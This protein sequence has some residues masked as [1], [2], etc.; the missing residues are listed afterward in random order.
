MQK[1]KVEEIQVQID[2][3]WGVSQSRVQ[4]LEQQ[5]R[6]EQTGLE[7]LEDEWSRL[8]A[9]AELEGIVLIPNAPDLAGRFQRAGEVVA[10][11][12]AP[13]DPVVRV[14]VGQD[15][16]DLVRANTRSVEAL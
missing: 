1:A 5:L 3:Q 6:L 8:T 11:V 10:Y 16:V 13:G 15:A 9:R 4:Q 2:A 12:R 7:R 14:V